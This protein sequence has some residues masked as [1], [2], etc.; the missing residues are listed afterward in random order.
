LPSVLSRSFTFAVRIPSLRFVFNGLVTKSMTTTSPKTKAVP[1][2]VH[3]APSGVL[4]ARSGAVHMADV[5]RLPGSPI[6][7]E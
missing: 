6:S 5:F 1:R 3:C 2:P 4:P 7:M